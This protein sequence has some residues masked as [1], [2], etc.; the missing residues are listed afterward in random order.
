MKFSKQLGQALAEEICK[1]LGED[2]S[3][4]PKNNW[5]KRHRKN[6]NEFSSSRRTAKNI[7]PSGKVT[8]KTFNR[9]KEFHKGMS[10]K[11][12]PGILKPLEDKASAKSIKRHKRWD[13]Y[14]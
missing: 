13:L 7:D 5:E 3:L 1:L 8:V 4:A 11:P 10:A 9:A 12:T 2:F 14:V 6:P